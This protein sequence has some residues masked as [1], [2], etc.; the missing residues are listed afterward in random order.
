VLLCVLEQPIVD[1]S[2]VGLN[3]VLYKPHCVPRWS[4]LLL[5]VQ[6]HTTTHYRVIE[7]SIEFHAGVIYSWLFKYTQAYSV[8]L[9][10]LELPRVDNSSVR[11]NAVLYK[12]TVCCCVY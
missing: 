8:L 10:V 1:N 12:P 3:A 11:L 2:S 5:A 7:N 9:C 4:Y 6:V